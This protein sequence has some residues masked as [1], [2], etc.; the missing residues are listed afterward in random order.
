MSYPSFQYHS[1]PR[2]SL[3]PDAIHQGLLSITLACSFV[4]SLAAQNAL[5]PIIEI[6]QLNQSGGANGV[7]ING[8]NALDFSGAS[9]SN[10]G[11]INNDHIDDILIGAPNANPN[12]SDNAGEVYLLF[13][14][15][16]WPNIIELSELN[17][18]SSAEGVTIKGVNADDQ[19]G[20]FVSNAGDI[21][22]DDIDD[23]LISAFRADTNTGS[24]YVVFGNSDLPEII[25][26]SAL[27][28]PNSANGVTINGIDDEDRSGSSISTAGDLNGD[29]IDDIVIGARFAD[30]NDRLDAGETYVVF[31]TSNLPSVIELSTLS[32]PDSVAGAV[33]F[34]INESDYSGSVSN[35]GDINTDGFDD[36]LIGATGADA[37]SNN[38]TGITYVLFGD[39]NLPRNI[40]LSE[41]NQS[42]HVNGLTINGVNDLDVSGYTVSSAGDV[43]DDSVD[44]LLI[45]ADG[46]DPNNQSRAGTSYVVFGGSN[47]P[48]NIDLSALN[49]NSEA[50]GLVFNGINSDDFSGRRVSNAGD[51][52]SD[53]V[54]DILIAARMADPNGRTQSGSSYLILGNS[55][56]NGTIELSTINQADSATGITING[57]NF[58]DF[59]GHS[60]SNAG[61]INNDG[62]DDFLIS[63]NNADPNDI[64][65]AGQTYIIFGIEEG[66]IY[67]NGFE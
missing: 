17:Q 40:Q 3:L 7:I 48:A 37:N 54:A 6:S 66:L 44:D 45:G 67:R 61:D 63:A 33:I 12:G 58:T 30:P 60:V 39:S 8:I 27:N 29:G 62:V 1:L 57:A 21:N 47:L 49:Q 28:Q 20:F 46:A 34:G 5:P 25:E 38:A 24:T 35:A 52:N 42:D 32:Q 9:V 56:L 43:N 15:A 18:S 26:L 11:D 23:V 59:S 22:N 31:G 41:L 36:L 51:I 19:S 64:D 14:R 13:G 16:N 50:M 55:N 65:R 4:T 53:G 10:A 2:V